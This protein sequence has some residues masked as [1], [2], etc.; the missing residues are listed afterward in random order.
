MPFV[1]IILDVG[2]Q[3]H[4]FFLSIYEY[5][6]ENITFHPRGAYAW[7]YPGDFFE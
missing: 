6:A 7:I 4:I 5:F 3:I 1:K 2:G